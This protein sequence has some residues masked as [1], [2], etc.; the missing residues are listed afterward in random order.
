ML[1]Y[2]I[3]D[4]YDIHTRK[5]YPEYSTLEEMSDVK[6]KIKNPVVAA[7]ASPAVSPPVPPSA[8]EKTPALTFK[9]RVR[10]VRGQI[11][12]VAYDE[13][14]G[15]PKFYDI[16]TSPEKP[17][18]RLEV[19]AYSDDNSL[20]CL[21][22][23]KRSELYRNMPIVSTGAPLQVLAGKAVLGRV[24]NLFGDPVDN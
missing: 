5:Q 1:G 12:E 19:Y 15:L 13:T 18:L 7:S 23:T 20:F 14:E 10:A 2:L 8:T 6:D 21:S 24:F 3:C 11:V 16:L 9:G 22:L 17:K 4:N